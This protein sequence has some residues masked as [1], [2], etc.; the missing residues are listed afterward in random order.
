[1]LHYPP[2]AIWL[3]PRDCGRQPPRNLREKAETYCP[4]S[5]PPCDESLRR[6]KVFHANVAAIEAHNAA[7]GG[8]GSEE[9]GGM[10]MGVTRFADLTE[11]E[12][13]KH[14]GKGFNAMD[15]EEEKGAGDEGVSASRA[16]GE[17]EAKPKRSATPLGE[18]KQTRAKLGAT[19]V[20]ISTIVA[21]RRSPPM[22]VFPWPSSS[23]R[24]SDSRMAGSTADA[25]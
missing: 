8:E 20:T 25:S 3:A 15:K 1:M 12:F 19:S 22:R 7:R 2:L 17:K 24:A 13:S 11:D 18:V 6:E 9:K 16:E 10:K 21:R 14:H 4:G 5:M 23:S